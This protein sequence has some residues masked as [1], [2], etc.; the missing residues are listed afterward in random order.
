M[1]KVSYPTEG[2]I[3]QDIEADVYLLERIINFSGQLSIGI[4]HVI[5]FNFV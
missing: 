4:G 2:E 3:K 1:K 5:N